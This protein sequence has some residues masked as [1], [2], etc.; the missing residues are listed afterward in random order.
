MQKQRAI[1]WRIIQSYLTNNNMYYYTFN[2]DIEQV[3]N[4][5]NSYGFTKDRWS[6]E[7]K[8]AKGIGLVTYSADDTC[9]IVKC[10]KYALL[11]ESMM[12]KDPIIGW[13]EPYR[14]EVKNVQEF[15]NICSNLA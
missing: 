2:N 9:S 14:K 8:D 6:C 13:V 1:L 10:N 12:S 11:S 3:C 15:L 4:V 7:D 5:L